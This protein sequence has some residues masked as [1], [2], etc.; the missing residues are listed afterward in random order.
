[1]GLAQILAE[2]QAQLAALTG[3]IAKLAPAT[4]PTVD[5][6]HLWGIFALANREKL[7]S[8]RD[9]AQRWRDHVGPAFGARI[10]A[11]VSPADVDAY[12]A[13]RRGAGAAIA[14]V[15]REIALL[16]RLLNFGVRRGK[17]ARSQLHGPGMTAELIH[18]EDNVRTTVIEEDPAAH[19][20]LD[21]LLEAAGPDLRAYILVAHQ[22]GP[23]RAEASRLRWS[24]ITQG[25]AWLPGA[26]TKGG[27]SGR[28]VP[29]SAAAQVALAALPRGESDWVF[30]SP[31]KQGQ[32][33]H[34]DVWTHRFGRLVRKLGLDGPD[35]GPPWL[36]DLRRSFVTISRRDGE[37]ERAIMN[38]SGHKTRAVF[39][40][41]DIYDMR[42]ALRFR[43]RREAA[44]AGL[45]QQQRRGPRRAETT[46]VTEMHRVSK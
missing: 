23:R 39:D 13:A 15:N 38:V 21:D 3:A 37:A 14:T 10:A 29:L 42:D 22:S 9:Y 45:R 46:P 6:T 24:R 5:V 19:L 16:R 43:E 28:Y 8:W 40:R 36:H 20:T 33:I 2:Q 35:G 17:L 26:E 25:V 41:Y 31:R 4:T 18:P 27:R 44:R 32:P 1:M 34:K 30:P 12:R 11:E 7:R